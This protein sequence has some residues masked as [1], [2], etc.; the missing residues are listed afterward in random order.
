MEPKG[1]QP[2]RKLTAKAV[3]PESVGVYLLG[4]TDPSSFVGY[5]KGAMNKKE[6]DEYIAQQKRLAPRTGPREFV[7]PTVENTV[8][9]NDDDDDEDDEEDDKESAR[10]TI[11]EKEA[12]GKEEKK[13]DDDD[14]D[15][16]ASK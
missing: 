3:S 16:P 11:P 1:E 7:Y 5:I 15:K 8:D 14:D 10:E 2:T 6:R 12:K 13:D 4:A 9:N